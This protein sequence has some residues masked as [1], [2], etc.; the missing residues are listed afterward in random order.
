MD[1]SARK[2]KMKFGLVNMCPAANERQADCCTDVE[3]SKS[4]L[5]VLH[6][7][8]VVHIQKENL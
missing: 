7:Q 6:M 5:G 2:K 8:H 3:T 4:H 1:E